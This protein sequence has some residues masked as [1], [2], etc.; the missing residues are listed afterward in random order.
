M[1]EL[2]SKGH[3]QIACQ[4]YWEAVH[5][6]PLEAGINHPNQYLE[7]SRKLAETGGT[8]GIRTPGTLPLFLFFFF[9]I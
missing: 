2:S 6:A 8:K 7:E 4:K 1:V 5:K 9:F 3:F